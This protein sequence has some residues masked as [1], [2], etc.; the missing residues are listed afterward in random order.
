[1]SLNRIETLLLEKSGNADALFVFPTDVAVSRWV[2]RLLR[3]RGGGTVAME[4][5][6]AW[7]TFKRASVRSRIQNK[8]SVPSVL[9]KIF[10]RSL[11]Q[12]NAERGASGGKT[13]FN[14]LIPAE[15]ARQ[16]AAYVSW[17]SGILP[18]LGFWFEKT[19]GRSAS[20][21]IGGAASET[22][23]ALEDS[24]LPGDDRDLF[25]LF[26]CYRKFLDDNGLFE[27]A[28]EKPP[29]DDNGKECFIFFPES[30]TD[31][32]EYEGI[33]NNANH[34]S[35]VSLDKND[36]AG[37]QNRV[38]FYTNSRSEITEAAL[39]I[40][41]LVER[42]GTAWGDIAVSIPDTENYEAYVL[43]EFAMRNIPVVRR[44]GKPLSSYPAGRFFPAVADCYSL[45]FSFDS[46]VALLFNKHL[47][48]KDTESINQLIDF[49]IRNNCICSWNE[50]EGLVDVW[51]D[52]FNS[53]AGNREKRAE[54]FYRILKR[55][56]ISIN[57][58]ASFA[59][60]R[61]HYFVFRGHFLDMEKC[62]PETDLVLSRC[63]SELIVLIEIERS[64]PD[65]RAPDHYRF[66]VD[67]LAETD[68]LAQEKTNGVSLLPYRTAAPV[69]FDCHV[70][71]GSSQD[72]LT[73][74][75][76]R[77]DFLP[78]KKRK[79]LGV[80]DDDAS[81]PFVNLHRFNSLKPA[82]FFCARDTFSGYAIPHSCL[83]VSDGPRIRYAD[84]APDSS[85]NGYF[86]ADS[87]R[88]ERL[89][90]AAFR[91][92]GGDESAV[93][94]PPGLCSPQAG[95]FAA[96][97]KRR[98]V[99]GG[100]QAE[101]IADGRILD[102]IRDR[103]CVADNAGRIRVS[104]SAMKPYYECA[105]RWLFE[106]VLSLENVRMEASVMAENILG[107]VYHAV[108]DRFFKTLQEQ[109]NGVLGVAINNNPT[110]NNSIND[111]SINSNSINDNPANDNLINGNLPSGYCK[112]LSDSV[113]AVFDGLPA[114]PGGWFGISA[115]T[116]RFLNAQR[117]TVLRQIEIFIAALL[118]YFGGFRVLG[119]E[120]TCTADEQEYYLY[121]K[122]D[123]LL[124]DIR[125][126][127]EKPGELVI[128]DF[129]LN[130]MPSKKPC[131]GQGE[132]GLEDF[133]LPM[134]ITLT[135][136]TTGRPVETAL[137]FSI[138]RAEP[139]VIFGS[140][141]D[142]AGGKEKT[143]LVYSGAEDDPFGVVL[144]EFKS[145][146]AQYAKEALSG[147]FT[148]VSTSEKK[149]FS[150]AY[151]RVCRT[152]YAVGREWNPDRRAAR[153]R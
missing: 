10:I 19:A 37:K 141:R 26:L 28:W 90:Y 13:I 120:L 132:N 79:A 42:E 34:V 95:G 2:D 112:L 63:V 41:A 108:L 5:F 39:Y 97:S 50:G 127:S 147:N 29:F 15:Y 43:G 93:R 67:H 106:N 78:R 125:D 68:Y 149:C 35:I 130:S 122:I 30:L 92:G 20:F 126:N 51:L 131:T 73:V 64:F 55:D 45:N 75:F 18:Q 1:M 96:W 118:R 116:V 77:L 36:T 140:I 114:L 102:L 61:Q 137:F 107:S 9:R 49:G 40:R 121:G 101:K 150:C 123:C 88:D 86:A 23:H 117:R 60:L 145:K 113:A 11:L 76:S 133:Q 134:Y 144:A 94:F 59:E 139:G 91:A 33:L 124:E 21:A 17:F 54:D 146:A 24:L 104:A 32:R 47:P 100:E 152:V 70:V 38:F 83:G 22:V 8:Q 44:T 136:K 12:E 87:Y 110:D 56:I 4:Q 72:N 58:A 31:F 71:L 16:G 57:R 14:S 69:P 52:A 151:H 109:A 62:L 138:T 66:F 89:F 115:L 128:A 53:P 98:C 142:G 74:V 105:L 48:W 82:V 7:D 119:S 143:G 25:A 27:P 135:E 111:N 46:V 153:E 99:S 3:L 65:V 129:K 85:A 6:I 84:A 81:L 103:Y 148:T 80:E